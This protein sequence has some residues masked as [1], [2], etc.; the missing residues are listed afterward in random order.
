MLTGRDV[1]AANYT[2]FADS[3]HLLSRGPGAGGVVDCGAS[4]QCVEDLPPCSSS[5]VLNQVFNKLRVTEVDGAG[6]VLVER[7]DDRHLVVGE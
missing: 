4:A 6:I 3:C 7:C 1:L 2:D 5:V